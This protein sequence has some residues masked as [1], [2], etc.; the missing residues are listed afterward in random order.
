MDTKKQLGRR[1]KELRK[2]AKLSQEQVAAQSEI[3]PNHLS[4][5]ELGKENPTLETLS[6]LA[7]ALN[8]KLDELFTFEHHLRKKELREHILDAV[9]NGTEEDLRLIVKFINTIHK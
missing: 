6:N 2:K 9:R 8:V 4:N 7:A 3:T 1:I 5:I